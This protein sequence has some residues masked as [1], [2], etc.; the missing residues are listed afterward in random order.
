MPTAIYRAMQAA[1]FVASQHDKRAIHMNAEIYVRAG[2]P[3]GAFR[4]VSK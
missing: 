1:G 3:F 4:G 2:G